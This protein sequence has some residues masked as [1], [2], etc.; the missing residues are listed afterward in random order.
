MKSKN[1]LELKL[2][3][4]PCPI[5]KGGAINSSND[6]IILQNSYEKDK[7]KEGNQVT[8]FHN[9]IN[10]IYNNNINENN[11]YNNEI[12][13]NNNHIQELNNIQSSNKDNENKK[14]VIHFFI[15]TIILLPNF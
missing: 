6:K 15:F 10:N 8:V 7:K 11:L 1:N 13:I 12:N 9:N 4:N 14:K 5:Q 3:R 2:K